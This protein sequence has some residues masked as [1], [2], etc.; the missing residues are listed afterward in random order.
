MSVKTLLLNKL[1]NFTAIHDITKFNI[2]DQNDVNKVLQGL[3]QNFKF[4][5]DLEKNNGLKDIYTI[6]QAAETLRKTKLH[7]PC[8]EDDTQ[9]P[10]ILEL[11]RQYIPFS[12]TAT[13]LATKLD[14][15]TEKKLTEMNNFFLQKQEESYHKT[16][17]NPLTKKL[18]ETKKRIIK[19]SKKESKGVV[20]SDKTKRNT[21]V[22]NETYI[23]K[24]D[25][26]LNDP[27]TYKK[28][29]FWP[30]TQRRF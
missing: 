3:G 10:E 25:R 28:V 1:P 9:D 29:D 22:D 26:C 4:P 27:T 14:R 17:T 12:N 7:I 24:C 16:R 20:H 2:N 15:D 21:L 19:I 18:D 13:K 11:N 8:E 5:Y 30:I 23:A 6:G